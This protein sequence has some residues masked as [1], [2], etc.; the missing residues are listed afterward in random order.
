MRKTVERFRR[1]LSDDNGMEFI[2]V[3][4][5][6]VGAIALAGAIYILMRNVGNAVVGV[7]S[8]LDIP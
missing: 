5:I 6:V 3:A 4:A 7:G 1:F 8:Q 2:Q